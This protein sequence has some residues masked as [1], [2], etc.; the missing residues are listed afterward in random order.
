MSM[1]E[2]G[3]F[4][5]APVP[6]ERQSTCYNLHHQVQ[7]KFRSNSDQVPPSSPNQVQIEFHVSYISGFLPGPQPHDPAPPIAYWIACRF[8]AFRAFGITISAVLVLAMDHERSRS[9]VAAGKAKTMAEKEWWHA[10]DLVKWKAY[11]AAGQAKTEAFM[12]AKV[13]L[14]D[15]YDAANEALISKAYDAGYADGKTRTYKSGAY[16]AYDA[17]YDAAEKAKTGA[18][19]AADNAYDAACKAAQDE[20]DALR[21][22]SRFRTETLYRLKAGLDSHPGG[23]PR[24]HYNRQ[25]DD[26]E[27]RQQQKEQGIVTCKPEW[28]ASLLQEEA[29][30]IETFINRKNDKMKQGDEKT[31]MMQED[32]M[33]QDN[34]LCSEDEGGTWREPRQPERPLLITASPSTNAIQFFGKR[35]KQ[36]HNRWGF[37]WG[38]PWKPASIKESST[39]AQSSSGHPAN[40]D[41][42]AEDPHDHQEAHP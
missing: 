38:L 34:E 39:A 30:A 13:A 36:Q 35:G 4:V 27:S 19:K 9:P 22:T 42:T 37:Y 24:S 31:K 18:Y 3:I 11:D 28:D 20:Y 16:N 7:I 15:A 33:E 32:R 1:R 6:M 29:T 14:A 25:W 21:M 2:K 5:Y 12:A 23:S 40:A 17:A 41:V 10:N 26:A 8:R